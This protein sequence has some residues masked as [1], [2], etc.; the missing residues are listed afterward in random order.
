[1]DGWGEHV[2]GR[3]GWPCERTGGRVGEKLNRRVDGWGGHVDRPLD[4]RVDSWVNGCID[5][6]TGE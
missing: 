5:G 4:R 3:V 6:W 2:S 1:V